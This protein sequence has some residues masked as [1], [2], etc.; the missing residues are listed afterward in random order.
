[1]SCSSSWERDTNGAYSSCPTK[2]W[3]DVKGGRTA[4]ADLLI[5]ALAIKALS[6]I[7]I[8]TNIAME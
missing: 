6:D 8:G 7:L 5:K 3:G 4:E 1:M 2:E